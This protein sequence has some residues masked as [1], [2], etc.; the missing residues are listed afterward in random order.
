MTDES[1][2][3]R[4]RNEIEHLQDECHQLNAD[5]TQKEQ[6]LERI[7]SVIEKQ[8]GVITKLLERL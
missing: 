6:L 5:L 1:E 3:L 7:I 2:V 4:L 8:A